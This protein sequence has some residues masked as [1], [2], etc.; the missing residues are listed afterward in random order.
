MRRTVI[1]PEDVSHNV[2]MHIALELEPWSVSEVLDERQ[3]STLHIIVTYTVLVVT[4]SSTPC[5]SSDETEVG[6]VGLDGRHHIYWNDWTVRSK[7]HLPPGDSRVPSDVD[8]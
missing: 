1:S 2:D 3:R 4:R 6:G 8:N 7:V 5:A